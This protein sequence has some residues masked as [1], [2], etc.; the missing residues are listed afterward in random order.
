MIMCF[1]PGTAIMFDTDDSRPPL[2]FYL[3]HNYTDTKV[4]QKLIIDGRSLYFWCNF[5]LKLKAREQA[6]VFKGTFLY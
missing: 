1:M 4:M 2:Q 6:R 3:P 5:K